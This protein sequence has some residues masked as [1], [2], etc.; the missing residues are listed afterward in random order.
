MPGDI[1]CL[2]HLPY[3]AQMLNRSSCEIVAANL[4]CLPGNLPAPARL[5]DSLQLVL[6]CL[7]KEQTGNGVTVSDIVAVQQ[8]L[9]QA[10]L[11]LRPLRQ[12]IPG[13]GH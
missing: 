12:R 1:V 11:I 2:Q 5:Q 8:V 9:L 4:K 3:S 13:A 7:R 10:L 6:L